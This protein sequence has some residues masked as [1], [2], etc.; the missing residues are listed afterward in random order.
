MLTFLGAGAVLGPALLGIRQRFP[1]LE[2]AA[3]T[4]RP[5]P[6][7][8]QRLTRFDQAG[9]LIVCG[10]CADERELLARS[11]SDQRAAVA[12]ANRE[13]LRQFRWPSDCTVL[14]VTNPSEL[15]AHWLKLG[16]STYAFGLSLDRQRYN[17]IL[18]VCGSRR[19]L[20]PGEVG[21]CH[22]LRPL[23]PPQ[24]WQG[25]EVSALDGQRS[26][27]SRS[28]CRISAET[29]ALA[30]LQA[31]T[32]TEF[33]GFRPPH[34]RAAAGLLDWL[35]GYL[36]GQP[37]EVSGLHQGQYLGG[38][39]DPQGFRVAPWTFEHPEWPLLQREY[40]VALQHVGP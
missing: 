33:D 10:L 40:Q 34:A 2:M 12:Q 3:L 1:D 9:G 7:G 29:H 22:C 4:R 31:W 25:L 35:T 36:R 26:A 15:Q 6:D 8:V 13:L 28:P 23:S 19:R 38:T 24:A 14:M 16:G 20:Q 21:G 17:E 5:I 39:L 18:A 30:L 11:H 37:V 27:F 32:A